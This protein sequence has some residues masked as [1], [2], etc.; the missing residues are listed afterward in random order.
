LGED[1]RVVAHKGRRYK[2]YV[3]KKKLENGKKERKEKRLYAVLRSEDSSTS[4]AHLKLA[5]SRPE[6]SADDIFKRKEKNSFCSASRD[7]QL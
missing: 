3:F 5:L 4:C 2:L 7:I 6:G 1:Q